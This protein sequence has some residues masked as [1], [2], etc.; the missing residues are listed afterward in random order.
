MWVGCRCVSSERL[1]LELSLG[2]L[3]RLL[4]EA[5]DGMTVML[6][7]EVDVAARP[8]PATLLLSA[9]NRATPR[10]VL[11]PTRQK[12]QVAGRWIAAKSVEGSLLG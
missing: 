1:L 9:L 11:L 4:L 8:V 5:R 7:V 10:V 2:L 12:L 6:A 3:L